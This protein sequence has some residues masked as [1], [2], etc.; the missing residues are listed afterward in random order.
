MSEL[1]EAVSTGFKVPVHG[2]NLGKL[3]QEEVESILRTLGGII[4]TRED[5]SGDPIEFTVIQGEVSVPYRA[6]IENGPKIQV[7]RIE[8]S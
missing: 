6:T 3:P 8:K 4:Q 2:K 1:K 7:E 5:L